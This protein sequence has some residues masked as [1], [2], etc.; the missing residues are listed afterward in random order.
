VYFIRW[1][2]SI[3]H[4]WIKFGNDLLQ[5]QGRCFSPGT[6]VSSTNKTDHHNKTEILLKV[7]LNTIKQTNTQTKIFQFYCDGQFYLWRKPEYPEKTIDLSQVTD[8]LYHIML[9]TSPWSRFKL[10]L[11][12]FFLFELVSVIVHYWNRR[13]CTSPACSLII[14]F[15]TLCISL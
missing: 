12:C 5:D 13:N 3:Q 11:Q 8:K 6:P 1:V 9:Y 7:A 15:N 4:C 14:R 10:S 2:Y